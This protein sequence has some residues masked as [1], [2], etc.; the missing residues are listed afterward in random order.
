MA[1]IICGIYKITNPIGKVYIGESKDIN[2]RWKVYKNPI[3]CRSQ[4]L[5][6][7]SFVKYGVENHTFEVIEECIFD[8]LLC[9]ERFWQD[10]Y[11]VLNKNVGLNL[12]L[13]KC[14]DTKGEHSEETKKKIG[15]AQKGEK[16]HM[17]GKVGELNP[18]YGRTGEQSPLFGIKKSEEH[19]EKV[20]IASKKYYENNGGSMKGVFGKD[21]PRFGK[22]LTV[23]HIAIIKETQKGLKVKLILSQTTGIFFESLK[24]A[25]DAYNISYKYL[26]RMLTG[27]RK[28]KTDLVYA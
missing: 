11:N 19:I 17:Y 23:E 14:G 24:E 28:N 22:T 2:D 21:H 26:S 20:R 15:E 8:E 16:N 9:K 5:L 18:C 10:E 25:S 6:Y 4:R 13:T 3:N 27:D 7:N 1:E 12:K